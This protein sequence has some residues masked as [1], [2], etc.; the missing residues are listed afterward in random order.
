[1]DYEL[2]V[3]LLYGCLCRILLVLTCMTLFLD[4]SN[5]P[6]NMLTFIYTTVRLGQVWIQNLSLEGQNPVLAKVTGENNQPE[7]EY[8]C[9]I[10]G[11][12]F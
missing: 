7:S 11:C 1:M 5:T 4:I 3:P 12:A 2:Y 9:Y 8:C 6:L 10:D